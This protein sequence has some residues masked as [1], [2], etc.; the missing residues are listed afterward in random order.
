[1]DL[2]FFDGEG[3]VAHSGSGRRSSA[4]TQP[5]KKITGFRYFKV[6]PVFGDWIAYLVRDVANRSNTQTPEKEKESAVALLNAR[7]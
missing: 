7:A 5:K 6:G 1:L 3:S 2:R 4:R